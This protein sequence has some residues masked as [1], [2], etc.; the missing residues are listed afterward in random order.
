MNLLY[1]F[2]KLLI[3]LYLFTKRLYLLYKTL[4]LQTGEDPLIYSIDATSE[5]LKKI[6]FNEMWGVRAS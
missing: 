1:S 6:V 2:T 3:L 4:A 5:I